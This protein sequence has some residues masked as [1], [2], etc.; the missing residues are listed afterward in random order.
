[1]LFEIEVSSCTGNNTNCN[2]V[3]FN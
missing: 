3:R 1:M 2:S